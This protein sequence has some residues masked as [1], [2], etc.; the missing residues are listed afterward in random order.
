RDYRKSQKNIGILWLLSGT[1][2]QLSSLLQ[3]LFITMKE[4]RQLR[5][6][7]LNRMFM[8][9]YLEQADQLTD[10]RQQAKVWYSLKDV[11]RIAFFALLAGN[12]E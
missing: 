11:V 4:I 8:E 3:F 7:D 12:D 1:N 10:T 2:F 9:E 5:T 6:K